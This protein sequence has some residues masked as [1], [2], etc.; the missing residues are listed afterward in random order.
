MAPLVRTWRVYSVVVV[1]VLV[2]VVGLVVAG[3]AGRRAVC[4]P[5]TTRERLASLEPS[6]PAT[7]GRKRVRVCVRV[8]VLV[9][10]KIVSSGPPRA[11]VPSWAAMACTSCVWLLRVNRSNNITPTVDTATHELC[12]SIA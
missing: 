12:R 7:P 9:F 5:E 6:A 10:L 4:P 2:L 3:V 1:G 11:T 8:Q